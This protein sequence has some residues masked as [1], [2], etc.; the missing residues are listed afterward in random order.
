MPT[1]LLKTEPDDYAYDDLARDRK[2]PWDGVTNPAA[3]K[4]LRSIKKGDEA[5]IYHTG[6]EK[7]VVGLAT[8]ASDPY[9]DPNR[10][11]THTAAGDVKFPVVDLKPKK[12]AASP[13]TL[14]DLKADD[15]F[16]GFDLI[17][18]PRLSVM[19]VPPALDRII[20]KATGL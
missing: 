17:S 14:A 18:Q 1:F 8:V 19:P 12:R 7:A 6:N 4:H 9:P 5:L 15:R 11:P 20:R 3:C 13:M 10:Q 16:R 2:T